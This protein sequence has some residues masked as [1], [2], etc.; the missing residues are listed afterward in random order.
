MPATRIVLIDL[1][2]ELASRLRAA[3][4]DLEDLVV[5]GEETEEVPLLVRVNEADIVI[6]GRSDASAIAMA[7]RLIDENPTLAVIALDPPAER[8]RIHRLRPSVEDVPVGDVDALVHIIRRLR[9]EDLPWAT[10]RSSS[11]Y[12][13]RWY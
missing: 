13:D 6:V 12:R 9:L 8:A 2:P 11:Q 1:G 5:V 10:D 4:K 7:E 3:S